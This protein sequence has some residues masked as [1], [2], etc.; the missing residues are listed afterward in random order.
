MEAHV[1]PSNIDT[2]LN[3]FNMKD[4]AKAAL[5]QKLSGL[6]EDIDG[7]AE[8]EETDILDLEKF[9][10]TDAVFVKGKK[11]TVKRAIRS[12]WKPSSP[13]T[14]GICP[15]QILGG[16]YR[17]LQNIGQGGMS[18]V[19]KAET[20]TSVQRQVSVKVPTCQ[21]EAERIGQES[22][23]LSRL[24]HPNCLQFFDL[25]F[26]EALKSNFMVAEFLEGESLGAIIQREPEALDERRIMMVG[27]GVLAGLEAVHA[28]F[29]HRDIKPS[30]VMMLP[31][32]KEQRDVARFVKIVDFGIAKPLSSDSDTTM[33]GTLNYMGPLAKEGMLD[34]RIDLWSLGVT[35][36]ECA[37]QPLP[38]NLAE[39]W[40]SLE[41]FLV[42]LEDRYF[43]EPFLQIVARALEKDPSNGFATATEFASALG[44]ALKHMSQF[45]ELYEA[46]MNDYKEK[47]RTGKIVSNIDTPQD[48]KFCSEYLYGEAAVFKDGLMNF[49]SMA[50]LIQSVQS[51]FRTNEDGRYYPEYQYVVE[52]EAVEEE[53]KDPATGKMRVKDKGHG[54]MILDDFMALSPARTLGKAH[55]AVIRL[56]TGKMYTPWSAAL[57]ALVDADGKIRPEE[58]AKQQLKA[59]ATSITI[60]YDAI[61]QLSFDTTTASKVWRGLKE[62]GLAL[63]TRF[64]D[65]TTAGTGFAG[66]VEMGFMSTSLDPQIGIDFSCDAGAAEGVQ[67]RGSVFEIK[68]SSSNKL[69]HFLSI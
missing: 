7:I 24:Q 67:A 58:Q 63:P 40:V 59:W 62:T 20:T 50:D 49:L 11:N 8:L 10:D 6:V 52:Q 44:A 60:L 36:L 51:E 12:S 38:P 29:V 2:W 47:E 43:S 21:K 18:Q 33:P 23:V 15:R 45:T 25:I 35:L 37:L 65:A 46:V 57:R 26:D 9:I 1:E 13:G 17:V 64:T 32:W 22:H 53:Q 42:E 68:V 39:Q 16:K 30:N 4:E 5:K 61:L 19:Y 55:C 34:V 41:P 56:Y 27:A 54:G 31:G 28:K 14:F 69:T 3:G 66:G 48:N